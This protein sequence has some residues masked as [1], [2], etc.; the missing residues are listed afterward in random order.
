VGDAT[1]PTATIAPGSL[2]GIVLSNEMLDNFSVHKVVFSPGG[3]AEVAYVVP[4]LSAEVWRDIGERV[5]ADVKKL[6][7]ADNQTIETRFSSGGN[8]PRIFLSRTAFITVLE[9]LAGSPD[10]PSKAGVIGFSEIYVPATVVPELAE[11]LRRYARPYAYELAKGGRGFVTYIGLGDAT[12][13]Q[14]AGRILKAGYVMTIDYGAN[15]D[16]LTTFGPYGKLRTYGPGSSIEKPDPYR[17]PT[18]NDITTDVNFSYLAQEGQLAGLRPVYYGYQRALQ[19]ATP[20]SLDALPPNRQLTAVKEKEFRSWAV[21]FRILHSFKLLVQQKEN[22]DGSFVYPDHDPL[23]LE[24][25]EHG[26]APQKQ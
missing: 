24:V 9:W 18:Q 1:D 25:D 21:Y 6:V 15:W 13:I 23:P 3:A 16:G 12:F 10:V 5:P 8:G 14:G 26:F 4:W 11:H 2:K 17:R 22:T 19:S 7:A 20:I